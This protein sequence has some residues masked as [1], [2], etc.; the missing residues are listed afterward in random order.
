M[1]QSKQ[2]SAAR[3]SPVLASLALACAMFVGNAH[4]GIPVVD[5]G[6]IGAQLSKFV[7]DFGKWEKDF[8]HYKSQ[9]D[10]MR[11]ELIKLSNIVDMATMGLQGN[12]LDNIQKRPLDYGM[13]ERCDQG[14]SG[15]FS[16]TSLLGGLLN[17]SGNNYAQKQKDICEKIVTLENSKYNDLV[18]ALKDLQ[19]IKQKGLTKTAND[20]KGANQNGAMDATN[21]ATTQMIGE[22]QV[23]AARIETA[24]LVYDGMIGALNQDMKNVANEALKGKKKNIVESVIS[25][26]AQTAIIKTALDAK[27]STCPS[28]F[29]CG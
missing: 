14:S 9:V 21:Q 23:I 5:G 19:A 17:I 1:K 18:V 13:K 26:V 4:A 20:S 25:D 28:G 24:T 6:H 27:E 10:H 8:A 7:Q 22:L 3:R 16:L 2:S 15:G 29:D 11:Q 12:P